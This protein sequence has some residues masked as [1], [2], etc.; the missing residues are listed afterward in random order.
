MYILAALVVV[1]AMVVIH[2][3]TAFEAT[4]VHAETGQKRAYSLDTEPR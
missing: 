4:P 1:P 2:L 3:I